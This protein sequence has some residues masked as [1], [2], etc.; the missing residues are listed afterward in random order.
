[1]LRVCQARRVPIEYLVGDYVLVFLKRVRVVAV[2]TARLVEPV[3]AQV[4]CA[5]VR[6]GVKRAAGL[7]KRKCRVCAIFL[8]KN[9]PK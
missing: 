4:R 8:T 7:G 5:G 3:V 6:A 2:L 1:M 9:I